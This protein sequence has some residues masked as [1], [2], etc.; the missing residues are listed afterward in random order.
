MGNTGMS[1]GAP[2]MP[3]MFNQGPGFFTP[4]QRGPRIAPSA[5]A[6]QGQEMPNY[7]LDFSSFLRNR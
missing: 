7:N 2:T 5:I 1:G 6:Q 3:Q 4:Q